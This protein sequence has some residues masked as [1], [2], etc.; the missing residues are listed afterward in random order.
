[1]RLTWAFLFETM[2]KTI[3]YQGPAGS[4]Q[5]TKMV[6]QILITT[7]MIG[8]CEALL[9]GYKAGLDLETVMQLGAIISMSDGMRL[10]NEAGGNAAASVWYD[11]RAATH[12]GRYG[13][14][15][16]D[17]QRCGISPRSPARSA[18]SASG[19]LWGSRVE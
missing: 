2:G 8:V 9:Y 13:G 3:V 10:G 15:R 6:N 7:D 5:H 11:R 17:N 12:A 1:M 16:R 14:A 19:C 4:G 18:A